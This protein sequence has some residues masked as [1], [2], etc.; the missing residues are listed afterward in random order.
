MNRMSYFCHCEIGLTKNVD[1]DNP[2]EPQDETYLRWVVFDNINDS[3]NKNMT[4]DQ[5]RLLTG[6]IHLVDT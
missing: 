3:L 5:L 1:V 2:R 6:F 4:C